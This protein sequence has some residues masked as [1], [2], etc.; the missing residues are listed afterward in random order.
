[1]KFRNVDEALEAIRERVITFP[2]EYA[3]RFHYETSFGY[4]GSPVNNKAAYEET[5]VALGQLLQNSCPTQLAA[6]LFNIDASRLWSAWYGACAERYEPNLLTIIRKEDRK[7][8]ADTLVRL[9]KIRN[10]TLYPLFIEELSESMPDDNVVNEVAISNPTLL[11]TALK[12]KAA[13]P[14]LSVTILPN[15]NGIKVEVN[16]KCILKATVVEFN[17]EVFT[18]PTVLLSLIAERERV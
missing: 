4:G 9:L 18:S 10:L 8:I 12:L 3:S 13:F 7:A 14:M 17:K 16:G 15:E 6:L 2:K 5:D 1:M 11:D